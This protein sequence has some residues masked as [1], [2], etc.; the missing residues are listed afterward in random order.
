MSL[1]PGRLSCDTTLGRGKEGD[2]HY[3]EFGCWFILEFIIPKKL[4]EMIII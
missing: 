2:N 1:N 4:K 3:S